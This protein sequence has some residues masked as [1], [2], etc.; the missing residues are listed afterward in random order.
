MLVMIRHYE[1]YFIPSVINPVLSSQEAVFFEMET[2]AV[3][4]SFVSGNKI[5]N[6]EL[7]DRVTKI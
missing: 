6:H 7:E 3:E 5:L 2:F 4:K 1:R